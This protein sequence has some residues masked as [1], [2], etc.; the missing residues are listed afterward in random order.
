MKAAQS[1]KI[2]GA[3][4]ILVGAFLAIAPNLLLSLFGFAEA[5]EVWVRVLGIVAAVIGYYYWYAGAANARAFFVASVHGRVFVFA[6]FLALVLLGH[7]AP[8]LVL[9]GVVDLAGAV[10]TYLALRGEPNAAA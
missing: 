1:V 5:K 4:L 3:Y 9:F 8:P 10:W 7:A 6:A 2:F